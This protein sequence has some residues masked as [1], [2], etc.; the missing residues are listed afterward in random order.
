MGCIPVKLGRARNK[1]D[2]RQ[3]LSQYADAAKKMADARYTRNHVQ[4]TSVTVERVPR[5]FL[6]PPYIRCSFR[7]RDIPKESRKLIKWHVDD[8]MNWL[9]NQQTA[10]FEDYINRL[11]HLTREV[12]KCELVSSLYFSPMRNYLCGTNQP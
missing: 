3:F 8:V 4:L 12:R 5:L 1:T 11:T 2:A 10:Q 7:D 6:I 9:R